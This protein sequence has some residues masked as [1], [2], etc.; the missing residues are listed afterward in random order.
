MKTSSF[1]KWL[2]IRMRTNPSFFSASINWTRLELNVSSRSQSRLVLRSSA[3]ALFA[4]ERSPVFQLKIFPD[5][6]CIQR[7]RIP[8]RL[9]SAPE[10]QRELEFWSETHL[11]IRRLRSERAAV[12]FLT[13]CTPARTGRM[14]EMEEF[15]FLR[16]PSGLQDTLNTAFKCLWCF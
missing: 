1:S 9:Y 8:A 12:S 11:H 6:L 10:S 14:E 5:V 13:Q 15:Y 16:D 3:S 2:R 4:P 7:G